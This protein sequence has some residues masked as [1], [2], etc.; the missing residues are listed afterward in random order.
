MQILR[1]RLL[2]VFTVALACFWLGG[3][4]SAASSCATP[5][6]ATT[7]SGTITTCYFD[8]TQSPSSTPNPATALL[9][10]GIFQVPGSSGSFGGSS[11]VGTG[12]LNPFVR[13]Q[14]QANG[15]QWNKS[16]P[17]NGIESG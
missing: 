6:G 3:V 2:A 12:V 7:T 1:T 10:G 15:T 13:I 5:D 8:L 9:N 16:D 17:A 4:A 11:I 14:E